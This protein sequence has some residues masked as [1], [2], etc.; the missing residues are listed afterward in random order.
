VIRMLGLLIIFVTTGLSN[1]SAT[2]LRASVTLNKV[3]AYV[4]EEILI[5]VRVAAPDTAFNITAPYLDLK[6]DQLDLFP[7]HKREF[8]QPIGGTMLKVSEMVYAVFVQQPGKLEIP[9]LRFKATLPITENGAT[10]NPIITAETINQVISIAAAP[11]SEATWLPAQSVRISGEWPADENTVYRTGQPLQRV[12]SIHV[13]GQ[14]PAAV[15]G[16]EL[17]EIDGVR[18]YPDLPQLTL[19]KSPTGI[20]GLQTHSVALIVDQAGAKTLPALSIDWWDSNDRS[21][22]Q[23]TL[24]AE[25]ITIQP[26]ESI[27]WEIERKRYRWALLIV[28][29]IAL[30]LAWIC[31]VLWRK[32]GM[33]STP[34]KPRLSERAA[35]SKIRKSLKQ[36]N[37]AEVRQNLLVWAR[38]RWPAYRIT[39]LEQL[40]SVAREHFSTILKLNDSLYAKHRSVNVDF[41]AISK[42]LREM[43]KI[44]PGKAWQSA[45]NPRQA[46]YPELRK[47]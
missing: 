15:P 10:R 45:E 19:Q 9:S 7:L 6:S 34:V 36:K 27:A 21:W 12:I 37:V 25:T 32:R 44:E 18:S 43:R 3:E 41:E 20:G 39:R 11:T 24:A 8:D 22:K 30:A 42:A 31:S 23:A 13:E 2:E 17:P 38:I 1:A 26:A 40:E 33:V 28:S 47:M 4:N 46:L 5:T 16:I 35:W 14:H 29:G